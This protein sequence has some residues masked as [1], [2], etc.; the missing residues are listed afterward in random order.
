MNA[1]VNGVA[2]E[3]ALRPTPIAVFDEEAGIG[4]Q[5]EITQSLLFAG[6][7]RGLPA[8]RLMSLTAC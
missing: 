4:G 2:R 5:H 1:E 3:V 8:M 6:R 7:V